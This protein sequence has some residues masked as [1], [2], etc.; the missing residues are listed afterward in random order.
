MTIGRSVVRQRQSGCGFW[1]RCVVRHV[2]LAMLAIVAAV[3]AAAQDPE[4]ERPQGR[5]ERAGITGSLRGGYWSSTRDLDPDD[6]IPEA[7]VW[8]KA[9]RPLST[10]ASVLVEGWT[11]LRGPL[12][13]GDA[14]VELREAF[15]DLRLGRLDVRA[16]RQIIAWGRA[17]GVN[18][19]NNLAGEDLTLLTPDDEDRR[20]GIT[21]LRAS[22]YARGVSLTAIW[23]PE[24]RAH[25][26][27]LPPPPA[28]LRFVR[29]DVEWPRDQWAVRAEQTGRAVDWS[30][31][32]YDGLDLL[33]DVSVRSVPAND[34]AVRLS[35]HRVRVVGGDMAANA[36]RFGLRAE[37]AYVRTDDPDGA[38]P[39][40]KNPF[41]FAVAGADRT[42]GE[43]LNLNVQYLYRHLFD[44]R[45]A[46]VAESPLAFAI[47]TQEDVLGGQ[48][49]RVQHGA[50]FRI[51]HKWFHDTLEAEC[52]AAGYVLPKGAALRPKVVYAISDRW[53]ALVGAE[54]FRGEQASVFGLLRANSAVYIE[55]RRYF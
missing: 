47:A 27:P 5:L 41:I 55:A 36:G 1:Q 16:G 23:M 40:V 24:F 6:H 15:L 35:H 26:F 3:P 33:P 34:P 31:S 7:M 29:D 28:G 37:A 14:S 42:F 4:P 54:I 11:A 49:R 44:R 32:F 52:A 50:S 19:T 22:Y 2:W 51:A 13:E 46:A 43:R 30:L 38:D 20:R 12:D 9:A 17:D 8:I 25:R 10:R 48:T 39:F 53:K 21:A 45:P 18:P